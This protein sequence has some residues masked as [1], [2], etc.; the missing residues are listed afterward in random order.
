VT[1]LPGTPFNP[2]PVAFTIPV[3]AT[4][5]MVVDRAAQTGTNIPNAVSYARLTGVFPAPLPPIPFEIFAGTPGLNPT[6][7]TIANVVQNPA[8]PG[9]AA[10]Q[11]SSFVSGFL[12]DAAYFSQVLPDGTTLYSDP[13]NAAVFTGSITRLPYTVGTTFVSPAP[14]NLYLQLGPG[15]DPARDLLIGQSSNRI[16][17]ITGVVVPEPATVLVAALLGVSALGG[18]ARRRRQA[19]VGAG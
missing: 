18:V 10:G 6:T 1:L 17:V 9:F 15:F 5:I 14:V 3:E 7:G 12:T 13:N 2:G 8:D 16:L 11:P 19:V 4:G